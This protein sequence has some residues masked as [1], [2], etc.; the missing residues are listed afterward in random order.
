MSEGHQQLLA[1][2]TTATDRAKSIRVLA[3][4]L[5]DDGG[6]DFI[7]CL[8]RKDGESCIEILDHVSQHPCP[9]PS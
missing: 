9:E 4:I 3:K 7:S 6:K 2:A 1:E 5:A 8:D